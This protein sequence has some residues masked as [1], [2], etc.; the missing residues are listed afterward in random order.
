MFIVISTLVKFVLIPLLFTLLLAT[1]LTLLERRQSAYSQ[2]RVG[3]NRAHFMKIG[4]RPMN[5]F[6]MLHPIADALKMFTKEWAEPNVADK[7]IFRLAPMLGFSITVIIMALI[8]FGPD[9]STQW[10]DMPMQVVRTDAGVLLIFAI[11]SLGIYGTVLAGWASNNRFAL[12]GG[13]RAAAQAVSYEITIGLTL[14]GAMVLYGTVGLNSMVEAQSGLIYGFLPNWGFFYQPLGAVLFFVAAM[15][16]TKRAPFDMPEGESEI[17]GYFLE[18]SSMGFGL[19][20][21]GEFAEIVALSAL[22]AT[23]FLGGWQLPW[24]LGTGSVDFGFFATSNPWV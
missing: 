17:I 15:A 23:V 6:G 19:F 7:W 12:M 4:G 11:S 14:V 9:I 10:G 22:F 21:L 18:Y 24:I 16:E 2:D 5:L 20:M 13:M 8:P 1:V 3:P